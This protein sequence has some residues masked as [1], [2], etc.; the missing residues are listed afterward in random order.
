MAHFAANQSARFAGASSSG[1]R[2]AEDD[3]DEDEFDDDDDDSYSQTHRG[4][5][6]RRNYR[7][8]A[9]AQPGGSSSGSHQ[10]QTNENYRE[11]NNTANQETIRV[12]LNESYFA[13]ERRAVVALLANV[14]QKVSSLQMF[15]PVKNQSI[16]EQQEQW[17]EKVSER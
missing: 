7:L 10:R 4:D 2:Q 6:I 17:N 3:N 11:T 1:A 13:S 5:G 8:H 9:Y 14:R 12:H 16:N 15:N